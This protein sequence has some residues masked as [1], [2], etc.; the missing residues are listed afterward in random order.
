M[1]EPMAKT[2][3]TSAPAADAGSAAA[4]DPAGQTSGGPAASTSPPTPP[5]ALLLDAGLALVVVAVCA[6]KRSVFLDIS[7]NSVLALSLLLPGLNLAALYCSLRG[8]KLGEAAL[9]YRMAIGAVLTLYYVYLGLHLGG[10]YESPLGATLTY[11]AGSAT[12]LETGAVVAALL[13]QNLFAAEACQRTLA[14]LRP[15]ALPTD[16][17]PAPAVVE[18]RSVPD[19]VRDAPTIIPT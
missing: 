16:P 12:H 7:D 5:R 15:A 1:S 4:K 6:W 9:H 10:W 13:L 18:A 14:A 2:D 19:S 8:Y 3:S 17:P 11:A